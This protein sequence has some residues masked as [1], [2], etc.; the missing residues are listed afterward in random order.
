MKLPDV[1]TFMIIIRFEVQ[2]NLA[3]MLPSIFFFQ[4]VSISFKQYCMICIQLQHASI[5]FF[6]WPRWLK[7]RSMRFMHIGSNPSLAQTLQSWRFLI[8]TF[9][10]DITW[11]VLAKYS[12]LVNNERYFST[13]FAKT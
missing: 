8:T 3:N 7:R 11:R 9:I 1:C 10:K 2:S 12:L 6:L 5:C 4:F 13:Q